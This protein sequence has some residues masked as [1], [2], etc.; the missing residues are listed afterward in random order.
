MGRTYHALT[1]VDVVLASLFLLLLLVET[2]ADQQQWVFQR[3]KYQALFQ[4]PSRK[5]RAS[6]RATTAESPARPPKNPDT[7]IPLVTGDIADGFLQSGLFAFSR[8]PNFW[9]EMSLWWVF[10]LFAYPA[11]GIHLERR[12]DWNNFAR[13]PFWAN[14]T[15]VGPLLLTLLFQGSTSLT[16]ELSARKYPQYRRYQKRVSR[17]LPW[18]PKARKD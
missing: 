17:L 9:A 15:A 8:H 16:E 7:S 13:W 5:R 3:Q 10:H 4:R 2:V 6:L 1:L 12:H 14:W 11:A 18:T